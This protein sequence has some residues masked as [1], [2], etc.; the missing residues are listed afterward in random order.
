MPYD[1]KDMNPNTTFE[2]NFGINLPIY[3]N[4][5]CDLDKQTFGDWPVYTVGSQDFFITTA[6]AASTDSLKLIEWGGNDPANANSTNTLTLKDTTQNIVSIP[7]T[8]FPKNDRNFPFGND[9]FGKPSEMPKHGNATWSHLYQITAKNTQDDGTG[10]KVVSAIFSGRTQ[11]GLSSPFYDPAKTDDTNGYG[12]SATNPRSRIESS[13][14]NFDGE[15]PKTH[16]LV[17]A[18]MSNE[19]LFW[20]GKVQAPTNIEEGVQL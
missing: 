20:L 9:P 14:D 5:L 16:Y 18:E 19:N 13:H 1:G 6:A 10:K 17:Q 2:I 4:S 8:F 12:R 3:L 11:V 15:L 7:I